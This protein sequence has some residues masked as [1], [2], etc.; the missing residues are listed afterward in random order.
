MEHGKDMADRMRT[1]NVNPGFLRRVRVLVGLLFCLRGR[2]VP[3]AR[4]LMNTRFAGVGQPLRF[5]R[6]LAWAFDV[7]WRKIPEAMHLISLDKDLST[8]PYWLT[9]PNPLANHPWESDGQAKLPETADVVVVGAGF[10]GAS[11]AYHWSKQ[12]SKP[13]VVL[14][15]NEAASGAAG[16]NGGIV[17]MA[18]G[19]YH[20]Y[21]VHDPVF[22]YMSQKYPELSENER[23]QRAADFVA[24]YVDAVQASHQMIKRTLAEEG[25]NCDYEQR[26]WVF[27]ADEVTH[28]KLEASLQMGD[29]LNHSDWVRRSPAEI[30]S[31]CGVSTELTG[32]ESV[33]A[34]T[35]HPAKWVWGLLQRAIESPSVE[36]FTRT[37]VTA[38]ERDGEG[39][40]VKT[41]RGSIRARH[42][43][44][45]T[46]SHTCSVFANFTRKVPDLVTPHKE[47]GM[48]ASGGPPTLTP[49]VGISG[50]LGWYTRVAAGGMVFGSDH[51]PVGQHQAG[52]NSP[53][54]F[55]TLY[56]AA[57]FGENWT[58]EE[59]RVTHEWTG[60]T[61]TTPDK[62]PIVGL[63]DDCGLYMIGGFAGAGSAVSFNAGDTIVQRILGKR[64][65]PEYHPEEFFSVERFRDSAHYGRRA[66]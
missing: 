49:Q 18:G 17:V 15:R 1:G 27:F 2:D 51:T 40:V 45:A 48:H 24:V 44:N 58:P 29:R 57:A 30:A 8:T 41:D 23:K 31:R 9:A 5:L 19:N 26:G 60:T 66:D 33:G 64:S 55:I 61:S 39:Y 52:M 6:L 20:G 50:P 3:S 34:A 38:V 46:E 12:G 7:M 21:Y 35:W 47:Q 62:F 36:L 56:R 37:T 14:E 13:L 25:I 54:R 53:S 4:Q 63:L 10:G 22:N 11:V 16:R 32:A 65:D 43:V 59:L 42:V 28:E